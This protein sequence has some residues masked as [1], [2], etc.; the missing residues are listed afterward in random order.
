M[1]KIHDESVTVPYIVYEGELARQERKEKRLIIVI[2]LT[3]ILLFASNAAWLYAWMQY[4]YASS[5]SSVKIDGKDGVAN[6]IGNDGD[7]NNGEDT[8]EKESTNSN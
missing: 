4:D 7:I 6:Y 8:G 2:A 1:S 5:D 3:I